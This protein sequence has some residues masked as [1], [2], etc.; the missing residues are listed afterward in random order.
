MSELI[1]GTVNELMDIR[2][3]ISETMGNEGCAAE[4]EGAMES[5]ADTVCGEGKCEYTPLKRNKLAFDGKD[6]HVTHEGSC[7][8]YGLESVVTTMSTP[9]PDWH[10]ETTGVTRI[11]GLSKERYELSNTD[12]DKAN[13]IDL[14]DEKDVTEYFSAHAPKQEALMPTC[15]LVYAADPL[16]QCNVRELKGV[17]GWYNDAV[18]SRRYFTVDY[19]SLYDRV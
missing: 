15:W 7:L 10:S 17:I 16:A 19:Y 11:Q 12:K 14:S 9:L 3:R 13:V 4:N 2:K 8:E 5:M 18:R 1:K 6:K